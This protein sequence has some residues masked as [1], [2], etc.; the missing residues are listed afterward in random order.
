MRF[1]SHCGSNQ[2]VRTVPPGDDRERTV[3]R[4]CGTIHYVNPRIVTGCLAVWEGKVLLCRRAIEPRKGLWNVP[5]GFLENG[6]TV[7]EGAL[8]ELWEEARARAAIQRVLAIYSIPH[9]NHIYIHFL[10]ELEEGRFGVGAESLESALF[11][12]EEIPWDEIA[13]HSSVFTLRKYFEDRSNGR[14]RT[15]VGALRW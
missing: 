1:C 5:S 9:V 7:E 6:E 2:L 11:A 10:G 12:E 3:C 4:A 14:H 8:R 13:F 15:H